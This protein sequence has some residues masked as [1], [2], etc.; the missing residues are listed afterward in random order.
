MMER[1]FPDTVIDWIKSTSLP[2]EKELEQQIRKLLSPHPL[3][4]LTELTQILKP[5]PPYLGP[6]IWLR[7]IGSPRKG[8]DHA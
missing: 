4:S 5:S 2:V 1:D 8:E 7:A 6:G 3:G